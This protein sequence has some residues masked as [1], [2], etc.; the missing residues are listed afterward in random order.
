MTANGSLEARR[1]ALAADVISVLLRKHFVAP[2]RAAAFDASLRLLEPPPLLQLSPILSRVYKHAPAVFRTREQCNALL[3]LKLCPKLLFVEDAE[4]AAVAR[5][6]LCWQ[7]T[8][9]RFADAGLQH[10][11][12]QLFLSVE[13]QVEHITLSRFDLFHG[14]VF[15]AP[16][17]FGVLFHAREYPRSDVY[18]L[19]FCQHNSTLPF[20]EQ[21]QSRRNILFVASA[22]P[23]AGERRAALAVLNTS[24]GGPLH[25]LLRPG[26]EE[27]HTVD[28][29]S[30]GTPLLDVTYLNNRRVAPQHRVFVSS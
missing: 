29:A 26:A 11:F 28:E 25:D 18:S 21:L 5:C 27:L 14:H 13:S 7:R 10:F 20:D 2:A 9:R 22:S 3:G 8:A 12:A 24:E 1:Q 16:G 23:A 19:G 30:L 6:Q 4:G 17:V 15:L